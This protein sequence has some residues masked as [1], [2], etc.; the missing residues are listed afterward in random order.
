MPVALF[1]GGRESR[2]S[3]HRN[4]LQFW[5]AGA[6]TVSPSVFRPIAGLES[7]SRTTGPCAG[8][9][10]ELGLIADSLRASR[11]SPSGG[12]KLQSAMRGRFCG[13]NDIAYRTF[14]ASRA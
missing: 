9:G 7:P 5:I 12:R 10:S 8:R 4:T 11:L 14:R 6:E 13:S 2:N 1:D 3:K